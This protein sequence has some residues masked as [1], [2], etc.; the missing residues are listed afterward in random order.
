METALP[1]NQLV[2]VAFPNLRAARLARKRLVR[3]GFARNSVDIERH[4]DAFEVSISTREENRA[5][6]RRILERPIAGEYVR[7]AGVRAADT[8]SDNRLLLLGFAGLAGFLL[9]RLVNER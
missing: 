6:A 4:D 5:R 7:E 2:A 3:A 9:Y 8:V 1:E